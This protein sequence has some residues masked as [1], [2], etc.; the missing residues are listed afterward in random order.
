MEITESL[1]N[2][3]CTPI[4]FVEKDFEI[5]GTKIRDPCNYLQIFYMASLI[6]ECGTNNNY[7]LAMFI[8]GISKNTIS[9]YKGTIN[10]GTPSSSSDSEM[11]SKI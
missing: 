2:A 9:S 5:W 4:F 10:D 3:N 1:Y 7:P 11:A 6:D 8:N